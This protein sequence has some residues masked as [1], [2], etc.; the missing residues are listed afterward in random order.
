MLA[1]GSAGWHV[2]GLTSERWHPVLLGPSTDTAA[3]Q[4]LARRAATKEA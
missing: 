2:G 4:G 3:L 1:G